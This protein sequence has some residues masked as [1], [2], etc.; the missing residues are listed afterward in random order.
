MKT[1]SDSEI[2]KE[3]MDELGIT[4][5]SHFS[6]ELGYANGS[7][8][9]NILRGE[10]GKNISEKLIAKITDRY[11]LVDKLFLRKGEGTIL[12][13]N[14]SIELQGDKTNYTLNDLPE[15]ILQLLQEQK[16]TNEILM[17]IYNRN[18]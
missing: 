11:P 10:K 13:Q 1:K 14:T 6:R 17:K 8:I 4:N 2:L 18:L 16:R 12:K 7:A 3:V 9:S 5:A 15:L